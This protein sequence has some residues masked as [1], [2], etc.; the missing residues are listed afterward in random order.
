MYPIFTRSYDAEGGVELGDLS[1]ESGEK[2]VMIRAGDLSTDRGF[3]RPA[4][5]KQLQ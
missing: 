3:D 5:A 2:F 1:V 4:E